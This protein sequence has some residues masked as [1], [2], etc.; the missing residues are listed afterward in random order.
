MLI[1]KYYSTSS[2]E[3]DDTALKFPWPQHHMPDLDPFKSPDL[4]A[5]FIYLHT[6]PSKPGVWLGRCLLS[7]RTPSNTVL[8]VH[9]SWRL[10]QGNVDHAFR[11][12]SVH[13][14][15]SVLF[16]C[17]MRA[18]AAPAPLGDASL[19]TR[20]GYSEPPLPKEVLYLSCLWLSSTVGKLFCFGKFINFRIWV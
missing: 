4:L 14:I 19:I 8:Q 6:S 17:L 16:M 18:A 12:R 10:F 15:H 20:R 13:Q 9:F 3:N 2:V 5:K 7:H 1:I 11:R